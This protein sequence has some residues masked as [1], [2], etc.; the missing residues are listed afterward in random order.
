MLITQQ[1]NVFR[2]V[3]VT[4]I[5]ILIIVFAFTSALLLTILLINIVKE[6][7]FHDVPI[8]H[9]FINM[10]ILALG[11]VRRIVVRELGVIISLINA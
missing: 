11:V 2:L 4:Q 9:S 5:T 8:P 1:I 3:Q 7:V 6:N 10:V